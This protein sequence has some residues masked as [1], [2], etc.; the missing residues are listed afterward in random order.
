M[1]SSPAGCAIKIVRR[2]PRDFYI[3]IEGTRRADQRSIRWMVRPP[4]DFVTG[5]N[6]A[7]RSASNESR[8][9][10]SSPAGCAIKIVRHLPRDFY[11][12]IRGTRR[13][14]Q[15]SI[16]WM[17]RPPR[18]FV[19]GRNCAARSAYRSPGSLIACVPHPAAHGIPAARIYII[20]GGKALMPC[21]LS[22]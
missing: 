16:R 17:V 2:L 8:C 9:A 22:Y 12:S 4:R 15:R 3:S 10:K 5:R 11:I 13:A 18:D 19:T 1:G 6:C 14:V 21:L 20:K 7:A